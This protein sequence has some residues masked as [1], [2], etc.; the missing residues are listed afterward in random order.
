MAGCGGTCSDTAE[1]TKDLYNEWRTAETCDSHG[2]TSA[3][4]L[5]GSG[6]RGQGWVT[7]VAQGGWLL[8]W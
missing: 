3:Q 6:L 5:P 2:K 7:G 1:I 4:G 8:Q